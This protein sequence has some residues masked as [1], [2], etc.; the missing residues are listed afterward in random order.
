MKKYRLEL[1]T[2]V[3]RQIEALPGRYR[4]RVRRVI[5]EL[6]VNPRPQIAQPLRTFPDRY[7]IRLDDYRIVYYIEDDL[8]IVEIVKVGRKHG[9]EFYDDI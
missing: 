1:K 8:L 7:R 9:P 3:L 4:Q 5:A 2:T 6:A